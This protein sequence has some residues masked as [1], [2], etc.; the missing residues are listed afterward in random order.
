MNTP[1]LTFNNQLFTGSE[2]K[3]YSANKILDKS[4]PSWE[5]AVFQFVLTWLDDSDSIIQYSSGTT[6]KSKELHLLKKSM[7]RSAE[8]TCRFFNLIKGQTAVLCLPVDYIAGKMMVIR[9]IVG[10]LNLQIVEPKS[11]PDFSCIKNI[12][13]CAMVPLQVLNILKNVDNHPPI[14]KL[15]IGGT[16]ITAELENLVRHITGE[17]YASYGMAETCSHVALR[18]LNSPDRQ[19]D[20]LALPEVLLNL[21]ERGCLVINAQYL[22]DKVATND[23][24]KFT[25][26]NSFIWLGRYDN[27]I[28]YGG[29][30]I[31][32]EEVEAIVMAKTT[33]EC[34]VLGLPDNKLGQ[35]LV[36]VFEKEKTSATPTELK[37]NLEKI[38]P[39]HWQPKDIVQVKKFPRNNSLKI[40]RNKLAEQIIAIFT[41]S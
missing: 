7:I 27:L 17:V 19:K 40:D 23:L 25:S 32:P 5:R 11:M 12:D 10:G 30:K 9:C 15:L 29:I 21:D 4:I 28:N 37:T 24:V 1:A 13:F 2:L 8:N 33:L 22:P 14:K 38:L 6:G 41:S 35:K 18:R 31:V 26:H 3:Q 39:R 34:A 20:Y 16:E 36:F